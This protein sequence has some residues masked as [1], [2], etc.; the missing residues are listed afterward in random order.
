MNKY[1]IKFLLILLKIIMYRYFKEYCYL[2]FFYMKI[3]ILVICV[4]NYVL[5]WYF[6]RIDDI[7]LKKKN[8]VK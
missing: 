4:M 7:F 8:V 2:G 6:F 5:L 3:M 1:E